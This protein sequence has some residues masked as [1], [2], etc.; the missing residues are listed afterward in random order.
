MKAGVVLC[1]IGAALAVPTKTAEK[2]QLDGFG[3]SS[4]LDALQSL[5][6]SLSSPESGAGS[7]SRGSGLPSF[8]NFP[9]FGG[10]GGLGGNAK[11]QGFGSSGSTTASG[12]K[13]NKEC[14]PLTFI[15]ARGS[16]EVGNMGSVVGPPVASQ[17]NSLMG[18]KVTVQG[19]DYSAT[20]ESNSQLGANGGPVMADLVKQALEQC[21][22]TTVVLGGYSQGSMVVHNAANRLD[23]GQVA[24]AVLFGDPFKTQS[25]GKLA[26]DHVKEYCAQGDPVCQNGANAMAHVSY[27]DNAKEA[28]QFLVKTAGVSSS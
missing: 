25:V 4:G 17:L 9:G 19:V 8:S 15:F 13:D 11:R 16:G 1:L 26:K 18:G 3:S 12:V 24:A 6:P 5:F 21:S 14:Q 27:G 7:S 10:P 2:R 23:A 22:N 20:A 28:A